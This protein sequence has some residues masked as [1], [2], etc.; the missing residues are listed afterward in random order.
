[1]RYPIAIEPATDSTAFGVV[2]PNLPGCFLAGDTLDTAMKGAEAAG[3]AWI[4]ATLDAGEA[5]P[6]PSSLDALRLKPAYAGWTFGIIN[7]D[8]D[9]TL[10][11]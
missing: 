2:V 8:T 3:A 4:Q 5:I 7:L 1:M 9:Q 10:A 11:R 6:A